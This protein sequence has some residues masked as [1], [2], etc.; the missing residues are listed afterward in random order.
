MNVFF[1][2][3]VVKVV[4]LYLLEGVLIIIIILVEG[5]NLSLM[6]LDYVVMKNVIIGFIVGLGK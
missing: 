2:Y 3:W 1:F 4:F 5:Y 6:F